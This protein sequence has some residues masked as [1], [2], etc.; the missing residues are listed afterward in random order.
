MKEACEHC[1]QTF[2]PEPGFYYG[3]M[4]ISYILSGFLC[5]GI[6]AF[7]FFV[8]NLSLYGSYFAMLFV[9]AFLFVYIFRISRSL[10]LNMNVKMG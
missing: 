7:F 2:I 9:M 1:G 5:L 10:W 6:F 3:A 4:F 8:L